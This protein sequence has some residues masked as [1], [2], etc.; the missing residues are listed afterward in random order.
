M[1]KIQEATLRLRDK[2]GSYR[3]AGAATGI[4]YAYLQRLATAERTDPNDEVLKILGLQVR[5][6][7]IKRLS[8][9]G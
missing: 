4:N 2:Y 9:N 7:Y 1:T 6:Q 8:G 5:R 3:K